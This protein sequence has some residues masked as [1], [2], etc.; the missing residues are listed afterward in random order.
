MIKTI[1]VESFK[2]L[3][4]VKV[5]LGALNVFVGANGSGKSNLLEA[6]GVLSA[7]ADG[8]VTDQTL[9]QRGVRPGVPQLYKSSFPTTDRRQPSHIY[10]SAWSD[11]AH[12]DVSLNNPLTDPKPAWKFKTELLEQGSERLASRGPNMRNNPNTENGLVALKA[13][14]L[15]EDDPALALLRLLQNYV[16]YSPTTPVLRG[17]APETQP[18]LPLGLSGGRLPEAVRELL[19]ARTDGNQA[20][21]VCQE[22]LKLIGWAKSFGWS[23][24]SHLS[25]S[26]AASS[27]PTVIR[28]AD[29]YMQLNRNV[30]S[31]YDA[32][33]GALYILFLA[34]LAT[35]SKAPSFFAIDNADH[36]LNPGLAASLMKHFSSWILNSADDRQLLMTSHNP[37]VL[38]G[39]PLQDDRIRLFTVDRDNKGKT[40]INRVIINDKILSMASKGWTLSRLWMNKLIGGMPN[41]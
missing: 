35:H 10:F 17:V 21:N 40:I 19:A 31:G 30:L 1:I 29:K 13:V 2:S 7:A 37:A 36:G 24:A 15:K 14:E 22:A 6:I 34:I 28:F 16:I 33:E 9:L 41:V 4:N 38:D 8:K 3:E 27:S 20:K 39:L 12:Y 5:E 11:L 26:S 18:R 32:S 23:P 25:L